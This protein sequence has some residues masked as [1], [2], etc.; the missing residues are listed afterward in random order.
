[1]TLPKKSLTQ[2]PTNLKEAIDWVIRLKND[3]A[4][5]DLAKAL[6]QLL[7]HDGSDVAM[8]VLD[9][10]RTVSKSVIKG[11][12]DAN[13]KQDPPTKPFYFAHTALHKLSLG[14]GPFPSG[15]A[16]I[17]RER[18]EPWIFAVRTANL[19]K[20]IKTFAGGLEKFKSC[21]L[22]GSNNSAYNSAPS[23]NN[24]TTIEKRECAA[25]L[26]GIMPVVYIGLTYLYWQCEG[27]GG[28]D[29]ESPSQD[30]GFKQFLKAFGY[31]E[32]DL[33]KSKKGQEIATQ[34]RSAFPSHLK[35]AYD[36]AKPK[37]P[38]N[39]SPTYPAF[40]GKLQETAHWSPSLSTSHPLTSL[41]LLSYYF[42]TNFLYTV[43]STIPIPIH[44]PLST[45]LD[46]PS[47]LKE[48]INWILR[49]T[50]KDGGG[51]Q[52]G[53]NGLSDKVKELLDEVKG[54]DTGLSPEE[55]EKIKEALGS[56]GSSTTGLI[57]KLAAD[58]SSS[59]GMIP[60]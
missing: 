46:R 59:L 22:Q 8:K 19:Q 7:K 32:N 11:L 55:F 6:E 58:F 3:D 17:S 20:L 9:K 30:E 31:A 14:L 13:K 38:S 23:W 49:V 57:S 4:I 34:L 52:D 54:A 33:N 43:Q 56:S 16:A 51:G 45:S 47:N 40:L 27:T 41:Y 18:L 5:N 26:L 24:L 53:T 36:T 25:I 37:Q 42:I 35:N 2:P 12:E 10:Y 50:G 39:I 48:A 28:W 1:M 44:P 29:Q 60:V 21:I 15:S